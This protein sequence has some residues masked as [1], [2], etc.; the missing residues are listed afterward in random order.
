[1]P[2]LGAADWMRAAVFITSPAADHSPSLGRAPSMTS[3]S[4]VLIAD[5]DVEVEPLVLGVQ[6]VDRPANGE[7]GA[8]RALR[9]VLVGV[10]RAEQRKH[11]VAAE[12][13]ERA[14]VA[15]ELGP[16]ARVVR[17]DRAP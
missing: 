1:M 3:A 2:S 12:L 11:G 7:R 8:N 4:P 9:V 16:D 17:R 6:L 13:L 14:A 10:R 5:A 15:L